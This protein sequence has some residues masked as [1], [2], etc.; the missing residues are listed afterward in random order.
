MKR[1]CKKLLALLLALVF[2]VQ[3]G[4][5][6]MA[7]ATEEIRIALD[8]TSQIRLAVP[9]DLSEGNWF[10]IRE[11]Q[12]EISETS[13]EKLYVPIQRTGDLS[14]EASV[15]LKLADITS[16]YGVNYKAE[17]YRLNQE[18]TAELGEFSLVDTIYENQDTLSEVPELSEEEME[19]LIAQQ[20]EVEITDAAGNMLGTASAA[21]GGAGGAGQALM[22][23]PEELEPAAE[24]GVAP[25]SVNPLQEARNAFTGT[26]SDRQALGSDVSWM[27]PGLQKLY[28]DGDDSLPPAE[29][30]TDLPNSIPGYLFTLDYAAGESVKFLVLTP[31]YSAK[32]DGDSSLLLT[33]E[34]P[35][36][37][38]LLNEEFFTSYV[39]IMDE[40]EP[41]EVTVSF[42]QAEYT[43]ENGKVILTVTRQGAINEIVTVQVSTY[44]GSAVQGADYSGVGAKLYFPMGLETRTLEI[45]VGHDTVEKDFYV[46]LTP[47][48]ECT[49]GLSTA[50]VVIPAVEQGAELM[51]EDR[52]LDEPFTNIT[53][54]N[55]GT[56]DGS[57]GTFTT[58]DKKGANAGLQIGNG[59]G[60]FSYFYDGVRLE[61]SAKI[62]FGFEG[63]LQLYE[64]GMYY[65]EQYK[66]WNSR[67]TTITD[68]D[69]AT[70][71]SAITAMVS[72]NDFSD[73]VVEYYFGREVNPHTYI[74]RGYPSITSWISDTATVTMHSLTPIKREFKFEVLPADP[75]GLRGVPEDDEKQLNGVY[76]NS[77][78]TDASVSVLSNE[79]FAL[80]A[81]NVS[82]FS[83]FAGIDAVA[84]DGSTMR[85][86][87]ASPGTRTINVEVTE[88]M[89]N[90]LA[91]NGYITWTDNRRINEK[92]KLGT[93]K[94]KPVFEK[95]PATVRVDEGAYGYFEGFEGGGEYQYYLGERITLKTALNERGEAARARGSGIGYIKADG[96]EG[97]R[98]DQSND[99]PYL[100]TAMTKV[101]LI[102]QP[103]TVLW[104]I[105]DTSGNEVT[106]QVSGEDLQYF[107]TSR[108]FFT[109]DTSPNYNPE[110]DIYTYHIADNAT[111]NQVM[112]LAAVVAKGT[113]NVPLWKDGRSDDWY[114]GNLFPIRVGTSAAENVIT[115]SIHR[116][117]FRQV[118]VV[119]RGT[120]GA[121]EINLATGRPGGR[122]GTAAEAMIYFGGGVG[123]SDGKGEFTL[124]ETRLASGYAVRY[125]VSYNG[126]LTIRETRAPEFDFEEIFNQAMNDPD[127]DWDAFWAKYMDSETIEWKS[128]PMDLGLVEIPSFSTLGAHITNVYAIQ[129]HH[130]MSDVK[131][132]EMNGQN[133]VLAARVSSGEGYM[134]DGELR[135]ENILGVTFYFM[136]PLTNELHGEFETAYD[137]E[138]DT[139]RVDLGGFIPNRPD[140]FTFGDVLYAQLTTDKQLA[141][142]YDAE[143]GTEGVMC[144]DP[145][146]TGYAV[147]S[148]TEYEPVLFDWNVPVDAE[149]MLGSGGVIEQ[150][151]GDPALWD[152][153]YD[154]ALLQEGSRTTYG[155]FP[156]I[157]E[158][159]FFIRIL[160]RIGGGNVHSRMLADMVMAAGDTSLEESFDSSL[161]SDDGE[162]MGSF[163]EGKPVRLGITMKFASLPYGGTRFAFAFTLTSGNDNWVKHMSNPWEDTGA[164]GRV[165][166]MYDSNPDAARLAKQW[167]NKRTIANGFFGTALFSLTF[168]VGFYLDFGYLNITTTDAAGHSTVK[169]DCVYLGGGGLIGFIGNIRNTVPVAT[170]VPMYI[171]GEAEATIMLFLGSGKD[172]NKTLERFKEDRELDGLDYGFTY[173]LTGSLSGKGIL[174]VGF[175]QALG[176]R[177]NL[178]VKI[179][180]IYSPT[181]E[182]WF[183]HNW[184]FTKRPF[185]YGASLTMS[186][187]LDA[188][189]VNIPLATFS[190][191]ITFQGYLH[192]FNQMRIGARVVRYVQEGVNELLEDGKGDPEVIR[193]CTERCDEI[194]RK[195]E[196]FESPLT[197][198]DR[199]RDYAYDH[200]VISSYEYM[201]SQSAEIGGLLGMVGKLLDDEEAAAPTWSVQPH[202]A[203]QW[204]AGDSAELMSAFSPVASTTVVEDSREQ[205]NVRLL[206]IGDG[207]LLMVFLGDD[208][209]R[210][211]THASV[212]KYA[213]YNSLTGVWEILPTVVQNDGTG[214][215]MP[216]LC[217]AEDD[218][219][220]S[221]ISTAPNKL[222][223]D[224][225]DP[226][227]EM[228]MM[229]VFSVRFP[230]SGLKAEGGRIN[231][232]DIYQ[233][234]DDTVYDALPRAVYDSES[235]DVLLLYTKTM[236]DTDYEPGSATQK[237]LDYT[238]G[239]EKVYSV[240]AYMLYDAA[241]GGWA[242]G[243]LYENESS[244]TDPAAKASFLKEWGGQRFVRISID[245]QS[246]PAIAE[247]AVSIGYNGLAA[248]AYTV[249]KDYD[250]STTNDKELY[251]QFYDFRT[252]KTYVPIRLTDDDVSQSMPVLTRTDGDTYLFWLENG[253]TL[254]YLNVSF[255][256]RSY[257][258]GPNE[259]KI[260][261]V[262]DDGTLA[263]GYTIPIGTVGTRTL[264]ND[265]GMESVTGYT[266][267]T[268]ESTLSSGET[269]D[270]L[271]VV[272]TSGETYEVEIPESR[273]GET[274]T[275]SCKE[276]YA[277]AFIHEDDREL[278]GE[279]LVE[280]SWSKP[281]RL[282]EDHK[283]HDGVAAA[284]DDEGNLILLH[285]EFDMIWHGDDEE[286]ISTHLSKGVDQNGNTY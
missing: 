268:N 265:K 192:L 19:E 133:T 74:L 55:G 135:H 238:V 27:S 219:I 208:P 256:L 26:I 272:W 169:H 25:A 216:D 91:T 96:K 6:A 52:Y 9:E 37:G 50:R 232:G 218:V 204:V 47:V 69:T 34:D 92:A 153:P 80:T 49:A 4:E 32:A 177:G 185:S 164:A 125:A 175:D 111:V 137:E 217:D 214:D 78:L 130:Y 172:P 284:I 94:I 22:L 13:G 84:P 79:S 70:F 65:N 59:W 159:N 51:L 76:I 255:M 131:I 166:A 275:E 257:T 35:S 75:L 132:L 141:A 161:S 31:L 156:F 242:K 254:K 227:R 167:N 154:E 196:R 226:T 106:V 243:Y 54:I 107:D 149:S 115:L 40:D 29:E 229:D 82:E 104:P 128:F 198:A 277:S 264:T 151:G 93:I 252:H 194:L 2:S 155:E 63:H 117:D 260:Y 112:L 53:S 163:L 225:D 248:Y 16:H 146:S 234:T 235:K 173:Q 87:S 262:R 251:V 124:P 116:D 158:L 276:I 189:F 174:G 210:S 147:I 162:M 176:L 212:L 46:T 134:L 90:A 207:R 259:E 285:N 99:S 184:Y 157:G 230:K 3:F 148:D 113:G 48:S 100:N 221:W 73:E 139:W 145:V 278:T 231:E 274:R 85:I 41:E 195:I 8:P 12:F 263:E 209:E 28:D 197:E 119:P 83:R 213:V 202:T 199:L 170:P 14:G 72:N 109:L 220:L 271:Y 118:K 150:A 121:Q 61:W 62:S 140:E 114:C 129:D 240:N 23:I 187:Y 249:D 56:V 64:A 283:Y 126:A 152:A 266:V 102:D 71:S 136:N 247:M 127:T 33:L 97:V 261:A 45:P 168:A 38:F 190:V 186:G 88:S 258:Y 279:G 253:D 223:P 182:K 282:T 39:M 236:P 67:M 11:R 89:I 15:V 101:F 108:G 281:Y 178:G 57:S 200:G 81:Q 228:D 206:N 17:I 191:P 273:T 171:G 98:L 179:E 211:E 244:F 233:V 123:L 18:P 68:V 120:V 44:D 188:V 122:V 193:S 95:I 66:Y 203:S 138:T 110:T 160:G 286:W 36:G 246:D 224:G 165:F 144:Y 10:F 105:F 143:S 86:A 103:Y 43:A 7:A 237:V 77:S 215:F 58:V 280:A 241:K 205:A 181:F 250:L 42:S 245:G 180:M 1:T 270:D 60:D 30:E 20:G 269:Y 222:T 201:A 21:D 24:E 267:L 239:G 183:P 142:V 5:L